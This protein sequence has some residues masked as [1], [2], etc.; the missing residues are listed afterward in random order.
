M[1]PVSVD[2][3]GDLALSRYVLRED[4]VDGSSFVGRFVSLA[5]RSNGSWQ[6]YRTTVFTLFQGPSDDAPDLSDL[7]GVSPGTR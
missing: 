3:F 1:W 4:F 6:V 2:V 7:D 5:R